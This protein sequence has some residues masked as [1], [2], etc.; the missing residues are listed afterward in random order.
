MKRH[1]APVPSSLSA[2]LIF[3]T[4]LASFH[5]RNNEFRHPAAIK[6]T[7]EVVEEVMAGPSPLSR[8]EMDAKKKVRWNR[9]RRSE[10]PAAAEAEKKW[11][12]GKENLA[13]LS[14]L[15]LPLFPTLPPSLPHLLA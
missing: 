6:R 9:R 13:W 15:L 3:P 7:V 11:G 10:A 2:R 5:G 8:E 14:L 12:G 4:F 1:L